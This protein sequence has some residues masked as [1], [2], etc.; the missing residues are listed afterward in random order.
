MALKTG[1]AI[2]AAGATGLVANAL[3]ASMTVEDVSFLGTL[4][5]PWRWV[6]AVAAAGLL[7]IIYDRYPPV[8]RWFI[9][10]AALTIVTALAA[11][12]VFAAPSYFGYVVAFHAVYAAVAATVF[13]TATNTARF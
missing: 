7:P 5:D 12:F 10:V 4:S 8:L 11:K 6:V 13:R 9:S 1:P 3:V 2:L